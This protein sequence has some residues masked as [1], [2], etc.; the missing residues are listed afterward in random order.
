MLSFRM[1]AEAAAGKSKHSQLQAQARAAAKVKR[2][3]ERKSTIGGSQDKKVE[4]KPSK[5]N[6]TPPKE[7]VPVVKA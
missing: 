4:T 5:E 1:V 6:T 3:E 2:D 7:E